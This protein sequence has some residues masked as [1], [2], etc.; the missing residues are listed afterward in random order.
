MFP[1]CYFR[2]RTYG[3]RSCEQG[4]QWDLNSLVFGKCYSNFTSSSSPLHISNGFWRGMSSFKPGWLCGSNL[5]NA[6]GVLTCVSLGSWVIFLEGIRVF[7]VSPIFTRCLSLPRYMMVRLSGKDHFSA[8]VTR[9]SLTLSG[10]CIW[11]IFRQYSYV[12][13]GYFTYTKKSIAFISTKQLTLITRS[14][15]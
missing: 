11:K 5:D 9:D 8:V 12:N 10:I 6:Q 4:T 1:A 3:T 2:Q 13:S 15:L 14:I 7:I